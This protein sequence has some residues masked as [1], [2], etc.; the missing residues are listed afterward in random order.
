[1]AQTAHK[2]IFRNA[3][4]ER[5]HAEFPVF[6]DFLPLAIGIHKMLMER[7][8][9]LD[10]AQ[11]RTALHHHTATTR[12]LKAL[13]EGAPRMGLD[14]NAAGVVTAEQQVQA[15]ETLRERL[16]KAAERRRADEEAQ[17]RQAKLQQL[18]EKFNT[19]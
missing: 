17:K 10:K 1:M 15:A 9:D 3:T 16:R 4:L 8:P 6:R 13:V 5:L 12:Y 18:A 14:G 11:L 7:L 2:P 19:R